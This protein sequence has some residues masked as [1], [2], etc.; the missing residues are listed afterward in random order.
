MMNRKFS[1]WVVLGNVF[2]LLFLCTSC[3]KEVKLS[4][5]QLLRIPYTSAFDQT[6]REYF[7]YLPKGYGDEPDKEWP[8]MLFLHG[9][10]ERGNGKDQLDF[11]LA[12]GPVFEAW[13]QRR[14][15]PFI[16]IAPQLHM[17][18]FDTLKSWMANRDINTYPKR[19]AEG[20]PPRAPKFPS[21]MLIDG[22]LSTAEYPYESFGPIRG[23]ET[24][25]G[26]LVTMLDYVKANYTTDQSRVYL[27]GLSY[28]GFGTWYMA[29]KYPE[30]FA[31]I[32]PIVGW[33][34]VDLMQPIVDNQIPVWC[35]AG[36]RDQ[37][38][39]QKYFY[40]GIN[41]LEELGHKD[42]RF[43]IEADMAHDVWTR[44]YAGEE[45]YNWLLNYSLKK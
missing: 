44:V 20:V 9:N 15:L 32:A 33:G 18:G 5:E 21:N 42:V 35:F 23:W 40:P 6:E 22:V 41:K 14:D 45:I 24:V 25:E 7:L 19:L 27:T 2:L 36:G 28:G 38:I 13:V 12:H 26:D 34:H 30:R 37:V 11:S 31:A 3:Q 39:E 1:M 8:V 4:E 10:G 29:S 16:I 43:T 17:H